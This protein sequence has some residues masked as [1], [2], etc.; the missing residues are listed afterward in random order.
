MKEIF[1]LNL[2]LIVLLGFALGKVLELIKIPKIIGYLVVGLIFGPTLFNAMNPTL[3]LVGSHLRRIALIIILMRSGL[4][5]DFGELKKIGI[6]GFLLS[7]VPASIEII[8]TIIFAPLVLH[9]DYLTAAIMGCVIAAVSP[10]IVVPRM[11]KLKEQKYAQKHAIPQ[12]V[13]AGSSLDDIFVIILFT[14]LLGVKKS[15]L[16]AETVKI[17]VGMILNIPG[18]ILLGIGGGIIFGFA[19]IWIFKNLKTKPTVQ[20]TILIFFAMFVYG[21]EELLLNIGVEYASLLSVFTIAVLFATFNKENA[22]KFSEGYGNLWTTFESLLFILVGA[23]T[24][25]NFKDI[26]NL[27]ALGLIAITIIFRSLGTYSCF[28]K[29]KATQKERLFAVFAYL[30]KATVQA[31]IGAVAFQEGVDPNQT[32]ILVSVICI[33]FTAP[34]G[35]LL[36]DLTYKKLLTREIEPMQTIEKEVVKSN[37]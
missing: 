34:L 28:L 21:I 31:S 29:S 25:I 15:L 19:L 3:L 22:T 33:I 26:T 18:S 13:M 4:A 6:R 9:V 5:L 36:M 17:S 16:K 35:A 2:S 20:L 7:F 14:I 37:I 11:L 12:T 24:Y 10:A 27:K 30:P 23:I 8:A 1:F 32:I